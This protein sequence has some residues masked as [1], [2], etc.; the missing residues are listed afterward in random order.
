M[1]LTVSNDVKLDLFFD[2]NELLKIKKNLIS[3]K[4]SKSNNS[5]SYT[6]S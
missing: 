5:I 4:M 6:N 3:L 1:N 2:E